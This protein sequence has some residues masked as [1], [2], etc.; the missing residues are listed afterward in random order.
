MI[1]LVDELILS[2]LSKDARQDLNEIWDFLRNY[3]HNLSLEEID[4]RIKTLEDEKIISRYTIS[5]DTKKVSHKIIRVVLVTFR[6]S[7]HLRSRV[8]GLKKYLEDAP[9]VLFSGRTRGGY[10]WITIQ[11]FASPEVAD[12]ESDIYRNLFGDIIQTYEVY[13]FS[14]LKEPTLNA[15][16]HT[17]K[18]YKKFLN[19]WMPPFI[20]R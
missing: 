12:E 11:V 19:E 18:E 5:I 6:P 14:P 16:T 4:S 8:E 13:D 3:G 9:F 10:D 15:F 1:D 2:A 20:G 17:E 7:Q